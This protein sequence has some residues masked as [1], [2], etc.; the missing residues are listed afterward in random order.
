MAKAKQ[1]A[2]QAACSIG[3]EFLGLCRT[4]CDG[5]EAKENSFVCDVWSVPRLPES[6]AEARRRLNACPTGSPTAMR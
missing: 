5:D 2:F 1:V 3:D 4:M 6:Q